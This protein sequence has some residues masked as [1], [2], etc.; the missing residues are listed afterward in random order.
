MLNCFKAD[1][2]LL[3]KQPIPDYSAKP[4]HN[5]WKYRRVDFKPHLNSFQAAR[6][7]F[8]ADNIKKNQ[9]VID[10]GSGTGDICKA[11]IKKG[12]N[13]TASDYT[14]ESLDLLA[15]NGV[16]AKVIDLSDKQ[17]SKVLANYDVISACE[18]F[19]HLHKPEEIILELAKFPGKALIFSVPNTGY[20]IY[21]L[22]L[23]LGKFPCQWRTQPSEHCRFWTWSDMKWWL[24]SLGL[25]HKHILHGYEGWP[26]LNTILPGLFARGLIVKVEF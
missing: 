11:L 5:Y 25:K 20:Y 22:R 10:I 2:K 16:P 24:D 15:Q 4:N 6:V 13:I 7:D 14:P 21:R 26:I 18:V 8:I 3:T 9:K 1:W 19:E 17:I 23:L 12:F